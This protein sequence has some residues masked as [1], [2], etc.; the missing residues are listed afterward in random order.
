[1]YTLSKK[2]NLK[3]FY[4]FLFLV[5]FGKNNKKKNTPAKVLS[6]APIA[7]APVEKVLSATEVLNEYFSALN[8]Y[9]S[10]PSPNMDQVTKHLDIDF[11]Y[12]RNT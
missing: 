11:L 2:S 5:G 1:M 12:I 8:N 9:F 7:A 10:S 6:A 3:R 4:Y